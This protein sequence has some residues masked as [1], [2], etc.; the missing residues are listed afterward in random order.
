MLASL[1]EAQPGIQV[2]LPHRPVRKRGR[3][4]RELGDLPSGAAPGIQPSQA[5]RLNETGPVGVDG[6]GD[7]HGSTG[8]PGPRC[9]RRLDQ[10]GQVVGAGETALLDPVLRI[11]RRLGSFRGP[12]SRRARPIDLLMRSG[13]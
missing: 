2:Y 3:L 6:D 8:F 5:K 1:E 7:S 10:A 4:E 13:G 11:A 9:G 12:L